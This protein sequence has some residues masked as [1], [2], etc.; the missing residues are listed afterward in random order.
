[1]QENEFEKSVQQKMEEL[2]LHPSEAVW[3]KIEARSKKISAA[4]GHLFF[5]PYWSLGF[6][7][8]DIYIMKEERSYPIGDQHLAQ[9]IK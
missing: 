8:E 6:Y 7:M 1:M 9:K 3:Q 5:C 2:K 4:G